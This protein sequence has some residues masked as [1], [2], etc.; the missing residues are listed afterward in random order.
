MWMSEV[1][2]LMRARLGEAAKKT[3]TRVLPDFLVRLVARVDRSAQFI[4]PLLGRKHVFSA[5]KAERVLGWT[6]RQA[7][8][9]ILD[10]ARSA[11]AIQGLGKG[12]P[13]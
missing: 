9:T 8:E 6:P 1:A 7:A 11:L 3:P 10:T 4:I 12:D 2:S 5:A 13:T